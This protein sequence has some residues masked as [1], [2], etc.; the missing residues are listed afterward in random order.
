[1]QTCSRQFGLYSDGKQGGGIV[2]LRL[3]YYLDSDKTILVIRHLTVQKEMR[4]I[5]SD[6]LCK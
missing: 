5:Y 2:N 3:Y 6:V 1:M 4:N